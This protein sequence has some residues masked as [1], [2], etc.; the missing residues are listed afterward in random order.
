MRLPTAKSAF[1][2]GEQQVLTSDQEGLFSTVA[3]IGGYLMSAQT[4]H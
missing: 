2:V 3:W 4:C 1:G